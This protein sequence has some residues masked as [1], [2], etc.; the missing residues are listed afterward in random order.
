M[1]SLLV[2]ATIAAI[3]GSALIGGVFFAFSNFI[4]K[5]LDRVPSSGGLLVMQTINV[6]VLNRWFLGAFMGTALISLILAA[7]SVAAWESTHSPYTLGGA[8]SYIGGTWLVTGIGNVPLN[9]N[10]AAVKPDAP[11]SSEVW[12]H[13]LKHWTKLNS[14]RTGAALLAA[15]LFSIGL[16]YA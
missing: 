5:A 7:M 14:Q 4:M 8:V 11:E 13:Y 16:I 15:V 9:N 1:S 2:A 6:T 12:E 10:L 3:V